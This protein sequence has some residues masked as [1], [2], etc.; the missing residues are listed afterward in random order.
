MINVNSKTI[1]NGP[2]KKGVLHGMKL[3]DIT[4]LVE[5]KFIE[6]NCYSTEYNIF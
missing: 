3:E 5:K 4:F 6:S 1:F 2:T